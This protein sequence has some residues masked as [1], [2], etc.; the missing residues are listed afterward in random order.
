[1]KKLVV[2]LFCGSL[3]ACGGGPEIKV[4]LNVR[5][6]CQR[7]VS[8]ESETRCV[9]N[10]QCSGGFC[11]FLPAPTCGSDNDCPGDDNKCTGGHCEQDCTSDATCPS[12]SLC[13]GNLCQKR[14]YCRKCQTDGNCASGE[15]CDHGQCH[16]ACLADGDCPSNTFCTAG[17]CRRP[18]TSGT[19]INFCNTGSGDLEIRVKETKL[20]GKADACAF[21]RIEW[22]LVGGNVGEVVTLKQDS[23]DLTMRALFTPPEAGDYYAMVE[24]YSNASNFSVLPIVLHGQAVEAACDVNLDVTCTP[25][26]KFSENDP[27][28]QDILNNRPEPSCQ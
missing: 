18:H 1:M 20:L 19:E 8:G 25:E 26:C 28:L 13:I 27:Q 11:W 15:K 23:C 24:V 4:D 9:G 21:K 6:L 17:F 2:W 14:G 3:A 7:A 22:A 16:K 5:N 12:G 10:D